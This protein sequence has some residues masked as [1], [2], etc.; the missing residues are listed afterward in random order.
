MKKIIFLF[1]V[2]LMATACSKKNKDI[3]L[4]IDL[5]ER[6]LQL[7]L[8][9]SESGILESDDKIEL[10]FTF[11]DQFDTSATAL[12]GI[13]NGHTS[14][15]RVT[16]S[17]TDQVGFT[18]FST[19]INGMN[20]YYEVDD[21]TNSNDLNISLNPSL[22]LVNNTISFDIPAGQT[23]VIVELE[24][25]TSVF[26]NNTI[27]EERGFNVYISLLEGVG[28]G[29]IVKYVKDQ[30][31][32]VKILDDEAIFGA[33]VFD[34][35]GTGL[36]D[37]LALFGNFNDEL[38]GLTSADIED[39]ELEFS[40]GEVKAKVTLVATELISECGTSEEVNKE[41]E[42]EFDIDDI[43]DFIN[44]ELVLLTELED[45]NG[46][47]EEYEV[48]GEFNVIGNILTITLKFENDG[49]LSEYTFDLIK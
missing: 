14:N 22:D 4:P 41:I 30:N 18:D 33:W 28:A 44:G 32:E 27:D 20:A 31:W 5:A 16:A 42:V 21:C 15:L 25:E 12:E 46:K 47:V 49:L 35:T 48:A 24:I 40:L 6:P 37:W 29:S 11:L 1:V 39:I 26:E 7:V 9:E 34:H 3:T 23:E 17:L 13:K 2:S 43:T 45:S 8:D 36:S 10:V 38:Q 19:L